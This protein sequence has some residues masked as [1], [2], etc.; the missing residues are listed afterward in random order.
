MNLNER[1]WLFKRKRRST[2]DR[3]YQCRLLSVTGVGCLLWKD[4]HSELNAWSV[5]R[6]EHINMLPWTW[7]QVTSHGF[8]FCLESGKIP[9]ITEIHTEV[10]RK[11]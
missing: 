4:G 8:T 11:G 7:V 2:K 1:G 3:L 5:F 10:L 6:F 9:N